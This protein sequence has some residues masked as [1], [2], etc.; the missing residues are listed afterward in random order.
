MYY[1]IQ[2][3]M[4]ILL[5]TNVK[6]GSKWIPTSQE[7]MGNNLNYGKEAKLIQKIKKVT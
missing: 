4:I 1:Y 3:K 7:C 2:K 5:E 6:W